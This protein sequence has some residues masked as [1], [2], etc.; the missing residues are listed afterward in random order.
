MESKKKIIGRKNEIQ[1]LKTAVESSKSEFL[2]VY[3]RRRVGKTFLIREFFDYSFDFQIAGLA[4]ASTN[5]QLFNFSNTLFRQ[6]KIDYEHQPKNWLEAFQRLIDY[7]ENFEQGKKKFLFFDELP[8]FDTKGSDFM[9]ALE[10][11]WNSWATNRRDVLLITCGSAASWMMSELINNTGGLHNRITQKMKIEPFNLQETE[12]MLESKNC[13]LDRHQIV[14]LYMA[15]GGIP[16]YLDAVRSDFSASQN[17]QFLFFEKNGLLRNEFFNLYRSIFK[18]YEIYEKIVATLATKTQGLQ[19]NEIIDLAKMSSGGTLTKA[20]S[21]L[22]ESG[23]ISSYKALDN[24][25]NHIIYRLSDFYTAFYMKFIKDGFDGQNAW[26]NLLDNPTYRAWQG[27]SFEQICLSHTTQIKKALGINGIASNDTSWR[28][29]GEEKNAQIDLLIDRRD[30]VINICEAKFS[31]DVFAI[32][33]EY[34]EKL[35][36][37]IAVF[38]HSSKT[39]K[40]VFLTMI[41]TYGVEK[42]KYFNA[43]VQNEVIMDDLFN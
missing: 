41:T 11:F 33:K 3:G 12:E 27:F 8:W 28:S 42:N 38:K 39:K 1:Q 18:K 5:Q 30:Q 19:R 7:L 9:I 23:F 4:N 25:S 31:T 37:K 15:M 43:L 35:R 26:L 22:E 34:S 20:L 2:A 29:V 40:A 16:Y 13:V 6:N 14:Q 36:S 21:D 17:I 32:S 24:K 10:H